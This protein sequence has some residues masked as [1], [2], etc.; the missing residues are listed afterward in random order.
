M[1]ASP[2]PNV[3]G[4]VPK[5]S[6]DR[7]RHDSNVIDKVQAF[8]VVRKPDLGL[9]DSVHPII[10]DF[11]N[12]VGESAQSRYYEASDW[13]YLRTS[14]H[15]LNQLLKSNK[16]SAQML[17]VVNQMLTDLLVSE[18]SRRRVRMEI[19]RNVTSQDAEVKN[20]S[21]YFKQ[22]SEKNDLGDMFNYA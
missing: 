19:E 9:G 16:P 18:G 14:L 11:W 21:D 20:L 1:R 12:S 17:T 6:E 3:V 8:G 5:R 7:I 13:Q 22:L 2:R 10:T 15:F 4:P